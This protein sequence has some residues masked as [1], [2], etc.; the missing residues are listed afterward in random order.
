MAC[1]FVELPSTISRDGFVIERWGR[2]DADGVA[3]IAGKG[4]GARADVT[5]EAPGFKR[6]TRKVDPDEASTSRSCPS[7]QLPVP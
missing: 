4:R 7:P 2:S 3:R 5:V 6:C 1:R